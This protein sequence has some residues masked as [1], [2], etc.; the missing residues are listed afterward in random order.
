MDIFE[1]QKDPMKMGFLNNGVIAEEERENGVKVSNTIDEHDT[2]CRS[3]SAATNISFQI[4]GLICS[5]MKE[6]VLNG[7]RPNK[8]IS[9]RHWN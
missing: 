4:H 1:D 7:E 2:I 8:L 9:K 5:F 6:K 3:S